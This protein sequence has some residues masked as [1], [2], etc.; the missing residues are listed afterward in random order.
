MTWL[1]SPI[2]I[3]V[4][5]IVALILVMSTVTVVR[6]TDQ[7]VILRLEQP[8]RTVNAYRTGEQF[9]RTQ[10]GPIFRL[11]FIDRVVRVDKRVLSVDLPNEPVL[12]TDQ[13]RLQIDA[14]ARFRV[15][16]PLKMV[17]TIGTEDRVTDQLQPL[18]RSALRNE[19]GKRPSAILLSPERGQVMDNIQNSLQK[20]A[21]QYG[22]SIVDVRIKQTE[23]PTGSPLDSALERMRTA[24]LQEAKTIETQGNKDAQIIRANADA[25]AAQIYAAAFNKDADFYNFWRAMRSYRNTFLTNAPDKGETAIILSPNNSYLKEFMQ[26]R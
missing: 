2:G 18:F 10:A 4:A 20:L 3:A 26:Q 6:E 14:Y 21:A 23:L 15:T 24:R 13:L 17:V 1:R 16:D 19:L 9:G 25:Q 8:Y 12:S 11:P 22:V 5:C 7:V